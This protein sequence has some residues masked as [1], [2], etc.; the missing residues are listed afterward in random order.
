MS[1][2]NLYNS[3]QDE[4]SLDGRGGKSAADLNNNQQPGSEFARRMQVKTKKS[5]KSAM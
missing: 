3:G 4:V 1:C 2:K 5:T